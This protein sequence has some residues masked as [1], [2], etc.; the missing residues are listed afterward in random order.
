MFPR[1]RPRSGSARGLHRALLAA[2]LLALVVVTTVHG[3]DVQRL[4][5]PVTDTT[6][7]LTARR[8]EIVTAIDATLE[9]DGVQVF[10][11][12]VRTT[13]NRSTSDF[14]VETAQL[15]SLG[16]NDVLLL[17]ALDDRTDYL[18]VSDGLDIEDDELDEIISET[19]EPGLGEGDFAGAV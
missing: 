13:G 9:E 1:S 2:C 3:E 6:G 7:E 19:L 11:L 8:A 18:W 16:V 15:N 12:F 5:G 17:V 14:A 10:V 4:S